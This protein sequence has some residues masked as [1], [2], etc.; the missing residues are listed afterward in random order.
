MTGQIRLGAGI[1][2]QTP[3]DWE[4][5]LRRVIAAID[6]ARSQRV[7]ILCLP[8]LCLTGY[9]C[10]D[11]FL[12]D[13]VV[14]TAWSML[15]Q[16]IPHTVGIA[17]TAGLP[18][19]LN[20]Y[21]HN[22][23]AMLVDGRLLGLSLK[24]NL[25]ND[26]LHYEPRWFRAWPRYTQTLHHSACGSI[27]AGDLRYQICGLQIGLE[28]CED[29][30]VADRPGRRL[31]AAG[32][33]VILNPSASHFAFG[34]QSQRERLVLEGSEQF[35]C[36]YVYANLVGNESGRAIYDGG[37]MI[38]DSGRML[39]SGQR[40]RFGEVQVIWAEVTAGSE[41]SANESDATVNSGGAIPLIRSSWGISASAS[42]TVVKE[43]P[44]AVE[45]QDAATVRA[46]EFTR[47]VA[48]G[49][50][51][52]LRKSRS[53]G[54]VISMSGGADSTACAVLVRAAVELAFRELDA[55]ARQ[56]LLGHLRDLASC[57]DANALTARLL[58]GVYQGTCNS[59]ETTR[60]AAEQVTRA[61]G[62]VFLELDVDGLVNSYRAAIE[63]AIGRQLNWQH[64]DIAL[65]NIQARTRSP[66]VWMLANLQG[67]LL[68]ATSNRSEA[69]VGY[70][71][72]DGDTSGGLSPIAGIDKDY[73]RS[74][75]QIMQTQGAAGIGP[76]P[77]LQLVNEQQPT[78]ELR[79]GQYG[80][81]DEGDLMPYAVLE[82]I[83]QLAIRE[84]RA[85]VEVMQIMVAEQPRQPV[86]QLTAWIRR[87]YQLWSSSQWKR[88]RIAPSF[89]LDEHNV[90]PRTWCR[91]P[92]LSGGFRHELDEMD[93]R[94][95]ELGTEPQS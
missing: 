76:F 18:V 35:D 9:G 68:L 5:N 78:A 49:L 43:Q 51:D 69:S 59:S 94:A 47:A 8:E 71:T 44:V 95:A 87:F 57:S 42:A 12:A 80:Q 29:A 55:N 34:K 40:L 64:D 84:R 53:Q 37:G 30:W 11:L 45:R 39:L 79:P 1:L 92:I 73:L 46:E 13:H 86:L 17:V 16:L 63:Q 61:L 88:E 2:N 74:W 75:L 38:A 58:T 93:D 27:P 70:T 41:T 7:A 67:A 25:A 91:F 26:G 89:H 77:V 22:A 60:H 52:Y 82:R 14:K 6:Q 15:Q 10:E 62:A 21:V 48:L 65:Q 32:V 56:Q 3:L 90:D 85:P 66:S 50:F 36:C 20:G 54:F 24:Q 72:M 31:A 83:E 81:T 19:L 23:A 28:I 4:G 33:D